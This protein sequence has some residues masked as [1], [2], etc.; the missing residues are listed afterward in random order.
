MDIAT[1]QLVSLDGWKMLT[2]YKPIWDGEWCAIN[3]TW[4]RDIDDKDDDDEDEDD[5][6]DHQTSKEC[7]KKPN[8]I[9]CL[10]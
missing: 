10:P 5:D 7:R 6:I 9:W 8:H 3:M 1:Q 2:E 4:I